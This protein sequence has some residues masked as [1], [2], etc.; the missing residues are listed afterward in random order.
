MS[1]LG[2]DG[3]QMG[4]EEVL[5]IDKTKRFLSRGGYFVVHK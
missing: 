4:K 5:N 2:L 3:E 1:S